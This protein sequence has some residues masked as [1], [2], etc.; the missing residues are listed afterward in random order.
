[1][2]ALFSRRRDRSLLLRVVASSLPSAGFQE[3][4]LLSPG[5]QLAT[6]AFCEA[7]EELRW[8]LE[9][10]EDMPQ[11]L[12]LRMGPL[13]QALG[14]RHAALVAVL[15]APDGIAGPVIEAPARPVREPGLRPARRGAAHGPER[16]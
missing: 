5:E 7:L 13:V 1:M 14:E 10:T 16:R 8:Y 3:L 9:H 12:L 11:T 15:G 2:V 4:A 6:S